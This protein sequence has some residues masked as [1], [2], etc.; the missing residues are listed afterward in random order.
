[1][2]LLIEEN[3][4][5]KIMLEGLRVELLPLNEKFRRFEISEEG[6]TPLENARIKS[7]EYYRILR[8]QCF[9]VIQDFI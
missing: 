6:E 8:N 3:L 4:K 2:V 7:T 9:L 1:M 5:H